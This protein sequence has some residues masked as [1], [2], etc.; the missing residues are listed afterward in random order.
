ME[1][2][3]WKKSK[4]KKDKEE[5]I[6]NPDRVAEI[7]LIDNFDALVDYCI[8]NEHEKVEHL[9]DAI[10]KEYNPVPI[11]PLSKK[12]LKKLLQEKE[13]GKLPVC[14]QVSDLKPASIFYNISEMYYKNKEFCCPVSE[15]IF[16]G[17]LTTFFLNF[18]I[19][20][21]NREKIN[22]KV[23]AKY[24]VNNT[25]IHIINLI[26][27]YKSKKNLVNANDEKIRSIAIESVSN[28]NLY[29]LKDFI[30]IFDLKESLFS[31]ESPLISITINKLI[32]NRKDTK[33][34]KIL[35]F[36]EFI[37]KYM[38][39]EKIT[40]PVLKNKINFDTL[41]DI[42]LSDKQ[43]NGITK[44]IF[45]IIPENIENLV[46]YYLNMNDTKQA[47]DIA[48]DKEFRNFIGEPLINQIIFK[49][50]VKSMFYHY[51]RYYNYEIDIEQLFEL[52]MDKPDVTSQL[53]NKFCKANLMHE[54]YYIL[55]RFN[56][57][58]EKIKLD[59]SCEKDLKTF[60]INNLDDKNESK[61]GLVGHSRGGK[62]GKAKPSNTKKNQ[63]FKLDDFN[64][65][66]LEQFSEHESVNIYP[67]DFFGPL[68]ENCI[69]L[70]LDI[71]NIIFIDKLDTFT[72][73]VHLLTKNKA[74]MFGI[75]FEWKS[76]TCPL[77]KD[78]GVSIMQIASKDKVFIFDM[79]AINSDKEFYNK[80][81]ETFKDKTFLGFGFKGDITQLQNDIKDFFIN[82][83]SLDI[84]E[85]Y[86]K[87]FNQN[88]PN[89]GEV[90]RT[91]LKKDLCKGEQ[92]SN[93]ERRPLRK[94]Q[95]HYASLDSFVLLK[96]FDKLV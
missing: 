28:I 30:E 47:S 50:N 35:K 19:Q 43:M 22:Q 81:I 79:F 8:E 6:I 80:F 90:C 14:D 66:F 71:N 41:V 92:I 75:D 74:T 64:S 46:K 78:E 51:N 20:L 58:L 70:D 86:K 83:K 4:N 73:N 26:K 18:F 17:I 37:F 32:D 52:F 2:T 96:I 76:K 31:N 59:S 21:D 55:K 69:S 67:E 77:E 5:I 25:I 65:E 44:R 15:E 68:T 60:L 24:K 34:E 72:K 56:F 84:Q 27:K 1:N 13:E 7:K 23:I 48:K 29:Y 85:M 53:A 45:R 61:G 63:V 12:K 39:D 95:L 9:L 40:C 93:W 38:A 82:C 42:S 11:Q 3:N 49:S 36:I 62:K 91:L 87:K 88:C 33:M 94:R 89:L 57:D 54:C 10:F 16:K